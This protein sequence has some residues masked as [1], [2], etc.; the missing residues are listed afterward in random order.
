MKP[1]VKLSLGFSA[2]GWYLQ[3]SIA[4]VVMASMSTAPAHWLHGYVR[5]HPRESGAPLQIR[6][7]LIEIPSLT[8]I[9]NTVIPKRPI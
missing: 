1:S 3:C 8:M 9:L 5:L 4:Y 6:T 7:L 2:M